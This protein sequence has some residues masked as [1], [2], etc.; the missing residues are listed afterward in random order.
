LF[1]QEKIHARHCYPMDNNS[2]LG[3]NLLFYS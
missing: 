3:Y 1:A 2:V